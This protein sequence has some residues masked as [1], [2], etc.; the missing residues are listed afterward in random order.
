[1]VYSNLSLAKSSL[2]QQTSQLASM[3]SLNEGLRREISNLE[4]KLKESMRVS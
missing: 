3:E 1:M 2:D 4:E